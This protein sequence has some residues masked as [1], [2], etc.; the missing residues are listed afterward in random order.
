M[1]GL[2]QP[3]MSTTTLF[4]GLMRETVPS[5]LLATQIE[6]CR[7]NC[8]GPVAHGES[9]ESPTAGIEASDGR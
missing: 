5:R 1:R 2:S 7:R 9:L 4:S 3:G 6:S 8:L